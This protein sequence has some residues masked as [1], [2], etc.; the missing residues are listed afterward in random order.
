MAGEGKYW[1]MLALVIGAAVAYEV[2]RPRPLDWTPTLAP[3]DTRPYGAE[4]LSRLLP[5]MIQGDV[6]EEY[7]PLNLWL[8]NL[9]PESATLLILANEAELEP[10]SVRLLLGFVEKGGTVLVAAHWLSSAMD[11]TLGIYTART[12]LAELLPF[13]Q[14]VDTTEMFFLAPG[15]AGSADVSAALLS[16]RMRYEGE[17]SARWAIRPVVLAEAGQ[18]SRPLALLYPSAQGGALVY[19]NAP[20]LL[21]NFGLL[22]SEGKAFLERLFAYVPEGTL[23]WW[24]RGAGEASTPLR[25]VLSQDSL[26]WA[27]YMLLVGIALFMAGA[28]RRRERPVPTI[29][30]PRNDTVDFVRTMGRLYYNRGDHANL[31]A[32]LRA[33]FYG[34]VR[35]TLGLSLPPT[36][37]AYAR[38]VAARS[39]VPFGDVEKLLAHLS[40]S[41][42]SQGMQSRDLLDLNRDLQ[43]FYDASVRNPA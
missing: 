26:R 21:S 41:A 11:D 19:T 23:V 34:Y 24:R 1:L 30:A 6:V 32:K 42:L 13:A 39:G 36:D 35:D 15:L 12:S 29:A 27:F 8:E 4:V 17:D 10:A 22:N 25:Y 37:P 9:A 33:Q 38:G 18:N 28:A 31:A 14:R 20:L 40:R 16:A 3:A 5:D 7:R 2:A 43:S